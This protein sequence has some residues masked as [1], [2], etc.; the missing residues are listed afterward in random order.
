MI[1]KSEVESALRL[2]TALSTEM[3]QAIRLWSDMYADQPPWKS[4]TTQTLNLPATLSAKV[5]KRVTLESAAT[6]TGGARADWLQEQ[7][8]PVWN[9]RRNIVEWA[10]AKGGLAFKPYLADGKIVTDIIHADAFFPLSFDSNHRI[11]SGIFLAQKTVNDYIYTRIEKHTFAGNTYTVTNVAYRSS[12]TGV[13]GTACSLSEVEEWADIEPEQRI[14][15]VDRPLFVYW[16]MPF[17]NNIDVHSPL[18]VSI[19][20]RAAE[21]IEQ[22]DRQYSRFLWEYEAGE[23][24]IHASRDLFKPKLNG[25]SGEV[26]LPKGKERLYR[27]LDDGVEADKNFFDNY[28]PALR[29]TSLLNG[30]NTLL[31]QIE[32]Q[33]GLASGTISDPQ[34]VEKTATEIISAK[35]E[36]YT[37]IK[38]IQDSFERA[39]FEL[40]ESIEILGIAAGIAPGGTWEVA[41]D[42]DDSIIVD[43][44]ARKK[45]FWLYVT[46]GKFP[47][48]RYLVEFEGYTE[49]E[50]KTIQAESSASMGD[51]YADTGLS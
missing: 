45:Q 10:A 11:T 12:M 15:N 47:F 9:A 6:F 33:C 21:T 41:F 22:L 19:Y 42:W 25:R 17:A 1:K 35:Q 43:H 16:P 29:D 5:A 24:A 50:A 31:R 44:E 40:L 49:D 48:W 34:Y 3:D 27:I 7:I 26:E 13:L 28:A 46:S 30:F 2:Q 8:T 36:T 51:P 32:A 20:S 14:V 23:A 4:D 38:D 18:G 39:L 37:T